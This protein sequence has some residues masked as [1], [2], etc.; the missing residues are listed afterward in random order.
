MPMPR[1][2]VVEDDA[3]LGDAIRAGLAQARHSVEWVRDGEAAERALRHEEFDLVLLDI[4]LPRRSG[5]DVL[6][7]ARALGSKIPV[8]ILSA[9]DTVTDRVDGL[10]AGADDYLVKPFDLDELNARVRALLRRQ[11]GSATQALRHGDLTLDPGAHAVSLNGEPIELSP[12]E[13]A[14][15]QLLLENTGKVMSRARLEEAVYGG[16]TDIGSNAVEVHIHHLRRKLGGEL[17]QTV[18]GVG[19]AIRK[20]DA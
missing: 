8:L 6:K 19:Y 13:F 9:R 5:L 3:I 15:L 14:L 17:I 1:L 20:A 16:D 11:R 2:L 7:A 18:R 4:G 12:R 10:D